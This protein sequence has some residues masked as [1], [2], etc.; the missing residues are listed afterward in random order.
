MR[1]VNVRDDLLTQLNESMGFIQKQLNVRSEIRGIN[2]HD[3]YELPL[4]ALREAVV[5][6][7]VHRDYSLRGTNI[8]VAVYDDRVEIE[9]PGGFTGE[10]P[11]KTL[12]KPRSGGISFLRTSSIVWGKWNVW[13]LGFAG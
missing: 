4:D 1:V 7:I 3:I 10:L 12:E 13:V 11:N 9:S 2:R 6:A 8:Y 5:N